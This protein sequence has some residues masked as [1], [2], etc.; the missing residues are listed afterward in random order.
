MDII[1]PV[2]LYRL[3][4]TEDSSKTKLEIYGLMPNKPMLG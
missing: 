4:Q 1:I 3:K 2:I